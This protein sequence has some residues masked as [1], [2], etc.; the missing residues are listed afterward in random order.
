MMK[1]EELEMIPCPICGKPF[2]KKRKELGYNYCVNCSTEKPLVCRVEEHGEGD[3]TYDSIRIMKP[4]EAF[5]LYKAE[6]NINGKI[7][8]NPEEEAAP[9]YS[10]FEQQEEMTSSMSPAEKERY[11]E[12]LENEFSGM[13]ER[14]IEELNQ[15]SPLMDD[16][17]EE[18]EFEEDE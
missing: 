13:S 12:E 14:S 6:H 3:H 2:P 17:D 1:I 15:L 7:E 9:D 5:A 8:Y 11:L 18:E 4:E 16:D 10:T